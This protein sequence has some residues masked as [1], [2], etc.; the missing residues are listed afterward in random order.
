MSAWS[1]TWYWAAAGLLGAIGFAVAVLA[2]IGDRARG[3]ADA[4]GAGT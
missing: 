3:R 4:L 2:I 1:D